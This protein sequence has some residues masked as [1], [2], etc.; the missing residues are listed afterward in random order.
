MQVEAEISAIRYFIFPD[1]CGTLDDIPAEIRRRYTANGSKYL[2]DDPY[3][4]KTAKQ[5]VG[6]E[7]NPYT[8][9]RKVFDYVRTHLRYE[10]AG[11]WNA[12]PVV[13]KRGTGSC[14]EYSFCFISL[15]RAAGLPARYVGAIVVRGDDASTDETFHRWPEMYLP[16]YG[17]VT[18]DPQGG[19]KSSPRDRALHIGCLANRYL[20]TTQGAGDSE[21]LGW[22]YNCDET[23]TTD[24]QVEVHTEAFAEWEPLE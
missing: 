20:I 2:T 15:C 16:N 6:D 23:Y 9:A 5:I 11:G 12:A 18:I 8:I 1:R 22:Y 24:P 14:S 10:L 4:Q 19:D 13:L 7:T 17:W 3:I 21:H